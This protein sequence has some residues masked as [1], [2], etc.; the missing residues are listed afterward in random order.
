MKHAILAALASLA[1]L[2]TGCAVDAQDPSTPDDEADLG[3][4][5]DAAEAPAG[6]KDIPAEL[7]LTTN[8]PAGCT[9]EAR[10][11]GAKTCTAWTSY[12]QCAPSYQVCSSTCTIPGRGTGGGT[13]Y[14]RTLVPRNRTRT[15]TIR[16]T[17]ATCVEVDY[18]PNPSPDGSCE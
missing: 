8:V 2:I 13:C 6:L 18:L 15:C 9:A 3:D 7:S 12:I 16:A 17:G 11:A 1:L 5:D 10:C 14:L 4:A